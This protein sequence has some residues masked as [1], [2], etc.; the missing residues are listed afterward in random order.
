MRVTRK[1]EH[2][3]NSCPNEHRIASKAFKTRK[4]NM[5]DQP[6]VAPGIED[7]V[8]EI[9]ATEEE[10]EKGDYTEVYKLEVDP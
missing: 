1:M 6:T 4:E 7:D 8:L 5:E 10:I 9:G 2:H 3:N